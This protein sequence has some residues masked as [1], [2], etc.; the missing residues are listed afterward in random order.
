MKTAFHPFGA[1]SRV[2]IGMH[3]AMLAV[4]YESFMVVDLHLTL[5]CGLLSYYA[6]ARYKPTFLTSHWAY[7]AGTFVFG[8][9]SNPNAIDSTLLTQAFSDCTVVLERCSQ[10]WPSSRLLKRAIGNFL[11]GNDAGNLARV[12]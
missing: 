7:K 2:C 3:L 4:V 11:H 6:Q 9:P 12:H 1:G 5:A 8:I 10:R